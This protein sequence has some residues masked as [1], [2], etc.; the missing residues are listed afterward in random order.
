MK[1]MVNLFRL[2]G[3]RHGHLRLSSICRAGSQYT[4]YDVLLAVDANLLA[5]NIAIS[6]QPFPQAMC[7]DHNVVFPKLALFRQEIPPEKQVD[8]HHLVKPGC[9]AVTVHLFGL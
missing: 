2:K 9:Q 8:S 1:V 7:E 4:N 5:D 3:Q 6:S